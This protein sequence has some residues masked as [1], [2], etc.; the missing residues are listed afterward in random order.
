MAAYKK[1]YAE[2]SDS[3]LTVHRTFVDRAL[4]FSEGE[5]GILTNG[6]VSLCSFVVCIYRYQLFKASLA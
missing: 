1:A 5:R 6:R 3:Y 2:Q 4:G